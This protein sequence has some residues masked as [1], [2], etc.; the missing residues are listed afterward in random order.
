LIAEFACKLGLEELIQGNGGSGIAGHE[1]KT[2][3]AATSREWKFTKEFPSGPEAAYFSRGYLEVLLDYSSKIMNFSMDEQLSL[4][5]MAAS[6]PRERFVKNAKY[7]C[8]W[9]FARFVRNEPPERPEGFLGNPLGSGAL[10]RFLKTRLVANSR[11]NAR[12]FF[13]ILQGVKR[14]CAKVSKEFIHEALVKHRKHMTI[15][16]SVPEDYQ[17]MEEIFDDLFQDFRPT[18]PKLWEA[19]ASASFENVRSEGGAR[20][21]L[22]DNWDIVSAESKVAFVGGTL[23]IG[24]TSL[25]TMP[26]TKRQARGKADS[27]YGPEIA[28]GL[29]EIIRLAAKQ[30]KD[31]QVSAIIEPLKVRLITKGNSLRYWVS[32]DFQK[33]LW[34]HLQDFP[35]FAL[36]GEPLEE[37]HLHGILDRE[38]DLNELVESEGKKK[39]EFD[40]WVSGDYSAATDTLNLNVT[41]L[42][43]EAALKCL[44]LVGP[45]S[46][47]GANL[48][49]Q[50]VLRS[51]L[52]EQEI[53][54]P[55][56]VSTHHMDLE[57]C[58]QTN[59]QLMGSTLSFPILCMVNLMC[60]ISAMNRYT[61]V[62]VDPKTLPVLVNGD[63][64][65]FRA[66]EKF[67]E[68]WKEE[69]HKVGFT[70]SLGKNYT[71]KE[72]L[73]ANSQLFHY[74]EHLHWPHRYLK[75]A[76]YFS[77]ATF[78]ELDYLN[79][80][81]LTGVAK[82]TGRGPKST[83]LWDY[84]N[85]VTKGA[86]DP[87]R[88]RM[89]FVH[90]HQESIK[91]LTQNGKW[92]LY[93]SPLLGGAGFE[94]PGI[95][96][97][98]RRH[99][100]VTATPF[101]RAWASFM[102]CQL[103]ANP[104]YHEKIALVQPKKKA[105]PEKWKGISKLILA[106]LMG[107]YD[108]NVVK[109]EDLSINL[110]PLAARL[111][112]ND[113]GEESPMKFRHPKRETMEKFR[114]RSWRHFRR[115]IF[116]SNQRILVYTGTR[117]LDHG[118][119]V[120]G[121]QPTKWS[122]TNPKDYLEEE[123]RGPNDKPSPEAAISTAVEGS[124]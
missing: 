84:F 45:E 79:P 50:E 115:G 53:H 110:P 67:Y 51:V 103:Y 55:K 24:D 123:F 89:R 77:R 16:P 75:R 36:T 104:H 47:P 49:Y 63:D 101:Q 39:I 15:V 76:V 31:V 119:L 87:E 17:E 9:P 102:E 43:F 33:Q 66:N 71:S 100:A 58:R 116:R 105:A 108:M 3:L 111:G 94:L 12:L 70:L 59:G 121:K 68:I 107:P 30:P 34:Q 118:T 124:E 41:K 57:S 85:L 20:A 40:F 23:Q 32:R 14:A 11:R 73:T 60:Y 48:E 44:D 29:A 61:G 6:W 46:L 8:S 112:M 38:Y 113:T 80:G 122:F 91:I 4:F 81:L 98:V 99:P 109:S 93:I 10:K 114:S 21:W 120:V 72:Y 35:Q 88:A 37:R 25:V 62:K 65:L 97:N 83:P 2:R 28:A 56:N 90:Y 22:Q 78:I 7:C 106:P 18:K 92:N 52:Y 13:G 42:A 95:S 74:R 96:A 117:D 69:V 54:Y 19:S 5:R 82:V 64:I 27:V 86:I 1:K 26:D